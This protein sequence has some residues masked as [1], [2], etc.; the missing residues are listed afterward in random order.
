M[1][2]KVVDGII[3]KTKLI[4]HY[5][6]DSTAMIFWLKNRQ[7]EKWRDKHDVGLPDFEN[8]PEAMLDE[9]IAR[10]TKAAK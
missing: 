6:P 8:M 7:K 4:K 5:P 1:D 10:L 2:I 9:I 3:V